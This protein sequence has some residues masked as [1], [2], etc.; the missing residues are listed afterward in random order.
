LT[1]TLIIINFHFMETSSTPIYTVPRVNYAPPLTARSPI[2]RGDGEKT[3]QQISSAQGI[4]F[5]TDRKWQMARGTNSTQ[6]EDGGKL[7]NTPLST[8][9]EK[10]KTPSRDSKRSIT[11]AVDDIEQIQRHVF[12]TGN[13]T[14]SIIKNTSGEIDKIR[15][16]ISGAQGLPFEYSP[17]L[18][19]IIKM[20]EEKDARRIGPSPLTSPNPLRAENSM[21]PSDQKK[22]TPSVGA[23]EQKD[24]NEG[25]IP[26]TPSSTTHESVSSPVS[27]P[28]TSAFFSCYSPP[29]TTDDR[30]KRMKIELTRQQISG[31]QGFSF[32]TEMPVVARPAQ[33]QVQHVP[34]APVLKNS[35]WKDEADRLR[36]R[37]ANVQGVSFP[38]IDV[39]RS[40]SKNYDD[41]SPPSSPKQL[42][43]S[44][45]KKEEGEKGKGGIGGGKGQNVSVPNPSRERGEES[46]SM[47]DSLLETSCGYILCGMNS[48]YID[49]EPIDDE[50]EIEQKRKLKVCF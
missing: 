35:K 43:R 24:K 38:S 2:N 10:Q 4:P 20:K 21:T 15:K 37:I 18:A 7:R 31:A 23:I 49:I 33:A 32:P 50:R 6:D 27:D 16:Q 34:P 44:G 9:E 47:E 29:I 13:P 19:R 39:N 22:K 36:G 46:R 25:Q 12:G 8:T 1:F 30:I 5:P 41:V 14:G 48:E 28:E 40:L 11:I 45:A 42:K 17:D 3:R 26:T